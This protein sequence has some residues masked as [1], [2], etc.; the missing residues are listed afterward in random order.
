M[1]SKTVQL[2][3]E[4]YN[5]PQ[6]KEYFANLFEVTIKSV[7]NLT[8]K[9]RGD[10]T[11]DRKL[12]RYRFINLLPS[13]IPIKVYFD[14]FQNNIGNQV[15]KK[16]ILHVVDSM[17]SREKEKMYMIE[18]K[19]LSIFSQYI[20][21]CHIAMNSSCVLKIE[22]TGNEKSSEFKFIKP[23]HISSN[24]YTHYLFAS[25]DK[26]NKKNINE[27]RSFAFNSIHSIEPVEY[28]IDEVFAVK[29]IGNAYGMINKEKYAVLHLEPQ[30]AKFF[31]RERQFERE[32]FEFVAENMDESISMKMYYNNIDEVRHLIQGWMPQIKIDKDMDL[33]KRIYEQIKSSCDLLLLDALIEEPTNSEG[34]L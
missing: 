21:M 22:Y 15:I 12:G 3:I 8:K 29:G 14:L 4:L 33:R 34:S 6:N 16:D 13:Y 25:Y 31:K 5:S 26:R 17:S 10:I 20:I 2:Y 27:N 7:E 1:N 30:A 24:G 32:E 19:E 28:K 18:T 11:Y 9:Y 23:H